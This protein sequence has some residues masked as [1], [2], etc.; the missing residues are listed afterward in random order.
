[1]PIKDTHEV[2]TSNAMKLVLLQKWMDPRKVFGSS[3]LPT[4]RARS[5]MRH[6]LVSARLWT[7]LMSFTE[8]FRQNETP[9]L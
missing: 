1:V 2:W 9:G 3:T 5:R 7:T 8:E 6:Y 4:F